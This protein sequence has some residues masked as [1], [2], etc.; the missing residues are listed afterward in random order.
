MRGTCLHAAKGRGVAAH[1]AR[2]A[3]NGCEKLG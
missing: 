2:A 1:G 3:L